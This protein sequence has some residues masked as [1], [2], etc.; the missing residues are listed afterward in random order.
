MRLVRLGAPSRIYPVRTD[1]GLP[2]K[3]VF[4]LAP[5][6][7][8]LQAILSQIKAVGPSQSGGKAQIMGHKRRD[9]QM[10]SAATKDDSIYH[11]GRGHRRRE[12]QNTACTHARLNGNMPGMGRLV[13]TSPRSTFHSVG[14]KGV[15][16]G[17]LHVLEAVASRQLDS[18]GLCLATTGGDGYKYEQFCVST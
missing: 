15:G 3:M 12:G 6:A 1:R 13:R 14:M 17:L 9:H 5:P 11:S 10:T 2:E 16:A 18:A 7:C 8:M 4:G